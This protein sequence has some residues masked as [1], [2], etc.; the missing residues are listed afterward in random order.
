MPL[1]SRYFCPRAMTS[2]QLLFHQWLSSLESHKDF[3][4]LLFVK[5]YFRLTLKPH[6]SW[7]ISAILIHSVKLTVVQNTLPGGFPFEA[8]LNLVTASVYP[9]AGYGLGHT[10]SSEEDYNFNPMVSKDNCF[11]LPFWIIFII[12]WFNLNAPNMLVLGY[13]MKISAFFWDFDTHPS[14]RDTQITL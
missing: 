11:S 14:K 6:F 8:M 5:F 12:H 3:S 13:M 10:F 1:Q 4:M 7:L 2:A 9:G